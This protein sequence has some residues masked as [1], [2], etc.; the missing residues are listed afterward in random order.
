MKLTYLFVSFFFKDLVEI[1]TKGK[2][3]VLFRSFNNFCF[4][5]LDIFVAF[6]VSISSLFYKFLVII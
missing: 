6:V 4:T 1:L 5:T 2:F 3:F